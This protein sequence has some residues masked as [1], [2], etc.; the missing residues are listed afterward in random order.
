MDPFKFIEEALCTNNRQR[1][2][3]QEQIAQIAKESEELQNELWA[4]KVR[5]EW[6][7]TSSQFQTEL[8]TTEEKKLFLLNESIT[9]TEQ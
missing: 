6:F 5:L 1:E 7:D 2:Y 9:L 4:H 3:V 8:M